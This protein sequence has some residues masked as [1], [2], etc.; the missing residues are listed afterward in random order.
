M[1][2]PFVLAASQYISGTSACL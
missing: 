2:T 1:K